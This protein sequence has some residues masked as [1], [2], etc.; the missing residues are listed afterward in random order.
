[1]FSSLADALFW[2]AVASCVVAQV[3]IVRSVLRMRG[4]TTSAAVPRPRFAIEIAWVIIPA[5]ALAALLV[6]T[7]R[8]MHPTP[9][10]A[11][12]LHQHATAVASVPR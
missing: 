5:L 10:P 12:P 9:T 11:V 2:I 1:M 8:T 4:A 7:W 3:A 6:G